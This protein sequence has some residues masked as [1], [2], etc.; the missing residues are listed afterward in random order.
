MKTLPP[1]HGLE[2]S[3][4]VVHK[5]ARRT[6]TLGDIAGFID[7]MMVS[8]RYFDDGATFRRVARMVSKR[9]RIPRG[10]A[11]A[12]VRTIATRDEFPFT[13][14]QDVRSHQLVLRRG[15]IGGR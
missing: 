9:W 1:C 13:A 8:G 12:A 14:R 5:T 3:G 4:I 6:I 2:H 7:A 15:L 10:K 11:W